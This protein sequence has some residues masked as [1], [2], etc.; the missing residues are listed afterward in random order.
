MR[1]ILAGA[2]ATLALIT[3]ATTSHAFQFAYG[4]LKGSFDSTLSVGAMYRLQDPSAVYYATSNSFDGLPG[5][6]TSVNTDDG[7]LNYK[8]GWVSE[9]LKGSHDLELRYRN[10]A[11][12][13]RGYYFRDL[14][15]EDT[16]RTNLGYQAKDRV[17]SGAELLDSYVVAKFEASNNIPIDVRFGRQ[18]LS[19]G[20]S[21]FIP[22]GI[23]VINPVELSKLR[24]P[25]AELKEAFLPVNMLKAS[26]G[27]TKDLTVEPFWLLEFRRN[28]LEPAG[29]YFS[30]N[31]FAS[32]GGQNVFLGFGSLADTGTLGAIPRDLDREGNNFT[33]YGVAAHYQAHALND[34]D[35][36]LY[37]A[38]YH[39]RS[40]LI[41]ART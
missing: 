12:F 2:V 25:G 18:V 4:E 27:L 16:A 11:G 1:R 31:D 30:T 14:K 37:Y 9:L 19:L 24:V 22:N 35:I 28:E 41:S 32:R 17:V 39:N 23:N 34:N 13:A 3:C 7:N 10:F 26:I 15:A 36:G 38:K 20:E 40:P 6:Q 5:I 29:T 21:T 33:Q 8:K